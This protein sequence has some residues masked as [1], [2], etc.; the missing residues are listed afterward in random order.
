MLNHI[1]INFINS[2]SELLPKKKLLFIGDLCFH[3]YM[4][5][6]KKEMQDKGE[7][8]VKLQ[9]SFKSLRENKFLIRSNN[10]NEFRK[11]LELK[12][13]FDFVFSDYHGSLRRRE[14]NA[15][16]VAKNGGEVEINGVTYVVNQGIKEILEQVKYVNENGFIAFYL[17]ES[18][19]VETTLYPADKEVSDR[20]RAGLSI[21]LNDLLNDKGFHINAIL[22]I[23]KLDSKSLNRNRRF[24]QD[25][26]KSIFVFSKRKT[27]SVFITDAGSANFNYNNLFNFLYDHSLLDI[28]SDIDLENGYL[29]NIRDFHTFSG[30]QARSRIEKFKSNYENYKVVKLG[31]LIIDISHGY[32]KDKITD[33][34]NNY[35]QLLGSFYDDPS[36]IVTAEPILLTD[37]TR[38]N[39]LINLEN[40]VYSKYVA[41]FLQSKLGHSLYESYLRAH[42]DLSSTY[43]LSEKNLREIPIFIPNLDVQ[44]QII[45]ANSKI[46]KLQD[47]IDLFS[48]SL[49]SN[50]NM[51]LGED[52]QK[53]DNMLDEVGKLNDA[54][55]IR[56]WIYG[57]ESQAVEFKQTWRLPTQG[58]KKEEFTKASKRINAV[59]FKVINSFINSSG[60]S[61][62]IG[63]S[64]E[65]HEIVGI[66]EELEHYYKKVDSIDKRVD[67]FDNAF[68]QSL[69][70]AFASDFIRL[71]DFH[72]VFL[73]GRIV[74]LV[75]CSPGEKACFIQDS[76]LKDDLKGNSFF[77]REGANSVPKNDEDLVIYC[78][79]RFP[80][81][82]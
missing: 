58:E 59:V 22:G 35:I 8:T 73:D 60:G 30:I 27:E 72:P 41:I 56:S 48:D 53:I 17:E 19:L 75:S 51:F 82:L 79:N 2:F 57:F 33:K 23:Q 4:K 29:L 1:Y 12:P 77:V 64:D 66:E 9:D 55:K 49:S 32:A 43:E 13:D 52:I 16:M 14:S 62:V 50:P 28:S 68:K 70:S 76:K 15:A 20:K 25:R 46:I 10:H 69:N 31:D 34:N 26:K 80:N 36:E 61:L 81:A 37:S 39:Y 6:L 54:E 45:D 71:I 63:V 24:S 40:E 11:E 65:K 42:A 18:A 67:K 78:T 5:F 47:S 38:S 7:K 3:K 74:Y 44:K 21:K